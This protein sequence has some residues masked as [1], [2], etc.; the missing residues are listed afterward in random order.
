MSR[1][2]ENFLIIDTETCN[3]L[4]QP[5]VYDIG[6]VICDREGNTKIE[7]SFMVADMFCDNKELLQSA[8]YNKKI[9]E[10]WNDYHQGIRE[11]RTFL[12][13][14]KQII[15]DMK[16]YKVK[17]V[18]AYN[19]YFDKN[20]LNTTLRY[21][22]KSRFRWFFPYSTDFICIWNMA[23]QTIA[24]SLKYIKF[25]KQNELTS[26]NG[27][28]TTSAENV[29]RFLTNNIN[30]IEKHTGLEDVRIE[31]QIFAKCNNYKRKIDRGINRNCWR[32]PQAI[33]KKH[34]NI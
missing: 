23:C 2:K 14:R 5:F 18:C 15:T 7:R 25:A 16:K 19:A 34:D 9:P 20:A 8:Y 13:I 4:E 33:A 22:T 6:Y 29:Y 10:Y 28:I 21:I 1:Q 3:T 30:F 11:M 26:K 24:S 27:N 17:R 32:I 31:T 12:N